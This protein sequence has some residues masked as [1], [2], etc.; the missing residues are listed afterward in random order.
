MI[1]VHCNGCGISEDIDLELKH[2]S[3]VKLTD[4]TGPSWTT[5]PEYSTHL[6]QTCLGILLHNYFGISA[7]G[8]LEAPAFIEPQSLKAVEGR[9]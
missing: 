3:L 4:F 2:I 5:K 1:K 7:E 9:E 8:Q 6:C